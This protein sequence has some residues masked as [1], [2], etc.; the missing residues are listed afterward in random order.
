LFKKIFLNSLKFNNI[1][2]NK[3]KI[4]TAPTYT[5]INIRA[6]NS[7][8]NTNKNS[9]VVKKTNIKEKIE[10]IGFLFIITDSAK[11]IINIIAK[12]KKCNIKTPGDLNYLTNI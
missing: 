8:S 6:K 1:T 7:T 11:K 2:T 9:D 10:Y 5:I 4:V 12:S 3:N